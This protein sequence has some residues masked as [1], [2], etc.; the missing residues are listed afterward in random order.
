MSSY[1]VSN[2]FS[3]SHLEKLVGTGSRKTYLSKRVTSLFYHPMNIIV[4][5]ITEGTHTKDSILEISRINMK[6]K[7]IPIT[8]GST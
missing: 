3:T 1:K 4:L 2:K 5:F 8:F 7:N 6:L